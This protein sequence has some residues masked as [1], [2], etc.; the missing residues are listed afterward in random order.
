M[1]YGTKSFTV[2][3]GQPIKLTFANKA[4]VPLP[5]NVV[6]GKAGTKDALFAAASK[7]MTDPNG[8]A[9]GYVPD[10]AACPEIL[11]H[12]ALVQPG[13]TESITFVCA[14]PGDYPFMCMFPGHS[15][16]MNGSIKAE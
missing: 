15:M 9:K 1:A 8:M 5:H 7:I 3:A 12:T 13:Q 4:A 11:A 2:K 14:T 10:A 6:I 16:L